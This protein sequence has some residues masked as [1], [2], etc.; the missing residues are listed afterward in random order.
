M[1]AGTHTHNGTILSLGALVGYGGETAMQLFVCACACACECACVCGP[2]GVHARVRPSGRVRVR[3]RIC[4]ERGTQASV[5]ACVVRARA[6]VCVR[7][8]EYSQ[9]YNELSP[10]AYEEWRM[11]QG[12]L[13]GKTG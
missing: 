4:A 8:G 13:S 9:A 3:V 10:D 5:R 6:R 7:V 12:T 2:A 1:H 11:W